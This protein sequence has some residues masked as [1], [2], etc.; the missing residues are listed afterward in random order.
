M[1]FDLEKEGLETILQ[2]WQAEVMRAVWETG[3][4]IDS[5]TAYR[6]L[7]R[8]GTPMSRAS[9]ISFLNR[10]VREGFLEYR[11]VTD[12]GGHKGLYRPSERAADEEGFRRTMAERIMRKVL[13]EMA[14][15]PRRGGG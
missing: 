11:E 2:P 10:M 6:H 4:E 3:D 9:V 7:K 12:K 13:E 5:R 1:K 15:N 8:R 14:V